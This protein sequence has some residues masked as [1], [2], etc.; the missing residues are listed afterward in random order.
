MRR[1]VLSMSVVALVSASVL[2]VDRPADAS[3]RC[4]VVDVQ[5]GE[6]TTGDGQNLQAAIDAAP[7]GATLRVTGRCFGT[8]TVGAGDLTLRGVATPAFPRAV[9]D[10]DALGSVLTVTGSRITVAS[11]VLADGR[12]EWGGGVYVGGGA[13]VLAGRAVVRSNRATVAGGVDASLGDVVVGGHAVIRGNVASKSGGGIVGSFEGDVR[14]TDHAVIR[15]N[16]AREN[17]G[18]IYGSICVIRVIRHAAIVRN[19][20]GG[21]GGGIYDGDGATWFR[22]HARVTNNRAGNDGGGYFGFFADWHIVGPHV[23][24]SPNQPDD[25][26]PS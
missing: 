7:D 23:V 22:G 16:H 9:L 20:A 17:G 13:L 12:A 5:T 6:T 25:F 3:G 10:A 19:T 24:L 8:F 2:S 26:P 14:I 11:L 1:V 21:D 18:G 15:G 4:T